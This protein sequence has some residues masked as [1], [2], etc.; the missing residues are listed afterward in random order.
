M[1][2]EYC[3]HFRL[4]D[5]QRPKGNEVSYMH[6]WGEQAWHRAQLAQ[7]P[8]G[9]HT[10]GTWVEEWWGGPCGWGWGRGRGVGSEDTEVKGRIVH[11]GSVGLSSFNPREG[12]TMEVSE[13]GDMIWIWVTLDA[14]WG[15]DWRRRE[16]H[17]LHGW[18]KAEDLACLL[19]VHRPFAP[20]KCYGGERETWVRRP[21]SP[22]LVL[23]L[24][25]RQ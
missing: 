24:L 20:L 8:W 7:R 2:E 19:S 16:G 11:V 4:S 25:A 17:P 1:R 12:T 21:P 18:S 3:W 14:V 10:P 23:I 13:Q 22:A 6:I 9:R 5:Q 15:R